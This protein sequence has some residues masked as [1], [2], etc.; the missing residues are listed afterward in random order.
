MAKR[1]R[2]Y[3]RN[4]LYYIIRREQTLVGRRRKIIYFECGGYFTALVCE[5]LKNFFTIAFSKITL[6]LIKL[7]KIRKGDENFLAE[8]KQ[9]ID[10]ATGKIEAIYAQRNEKDTLKLATEVLELLTILCKKEQIPKGTPESI[11]DF[12][13][14]GL[15]D[16]RPPHEIKIGGRR[17]D[18]YSLKVIVRPAV[19]SVYFNMTFEPEAYANK[20][21]SD[22]IEKVSSEIKEIAEQMGLKPIQLVGDDRIYYITP[23]IDRRFLTP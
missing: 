16:A 12:V 3:N 17:V 13:K 19:N 8:I 15:L 18:I 21:V 14:N 7:F 23:Q 22:I 9:E 10:K 20:D 11:I 5:R 4:V 6:E 2:E 1:A